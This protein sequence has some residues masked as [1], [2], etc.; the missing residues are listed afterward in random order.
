MPLLCD[1]FLDPQEALSSVFRSCCTL[2]NALP[3]RRFCFYL[4][5]ALSLLFLFCLS[6]LRNSQIT[7]HWLSMTN[8]AVTKQIGQ[9]TP[10]NVLLMFQPGSCASFYRRWWEQACACVSRM[11]IVAKISR[12]SQL[13]SNVLQR[14]RI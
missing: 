7:G 12:H 8:D 2:A 3:Q 5:N 6:S 11:R 14:L 13:F 4:P 10:N 9:R 1:K